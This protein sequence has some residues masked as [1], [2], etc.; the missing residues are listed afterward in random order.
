MHRK[1]TEQ[2]LKDLD[3]KMVF[4]TGPRQVGKTW[5]AKKIS[6]KFEKP[7]YLNYDNFED[8]EIIKNEQWPE[9]TDLLVLD[10]IHKMKDWKNFLKGVYDTKP[11]KLKIL[12]TG[13]ARL[14]TFRQ[15][16]DSLAGR[17][18][19]HRLLPF[20]LAEFKS[21]DYEDDMD[22]LIER[23]GFPEPFL[24]ESD[25][26]ARRWRTLYLDGLIR[27]DVLDFERIHDFE[28]VKTIFELLRRKV[29]SHIS[30][31]SIARDVNISP[32]TVK[33]Y[34]EIFEAL[35]IIFRINPYSRNIA[36]SVLKEPKVYFF[37][38]GLVE[39]GEGAKFENFVALSLFKDVL[40]RNDN[41]GEEN[42]LK[43]LKTKEGKEVDFA[44]VNSK[45]EISK[46]IEAKNKDSKPAKNLKYFSGKYDFKGVQLVSNLKRE[47]EVDG[48]EARRARHYLK[49]LFL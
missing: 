2:I 21:G 37:D 25:T 28:A 31:N 3:K 42:S 1:Q 44:L 11:E 40:A 7:A 12:V 45:N 14:E 36:R 29:G 27:T 38:N 47:K 24:A 43:Y 8:R 23:G 48:I 26:E 35:Y 18:Y 41:L 17:F 10:E 30:Y 39:G 20:S 49:D 9:S 46:I 33:K 15:A 5:L 16:G 34:I 32:I 13:S 19:V 6:E 22:R 4:I